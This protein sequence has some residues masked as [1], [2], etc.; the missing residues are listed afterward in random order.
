[1]VLT[2]YDEDADS[3]DEPSQWRV[4]N[5]WGDDHGDKGYALLKKNWFREYVYEVAV[6]KDILSDEHGAALLEEPIQLPPWDPMG[7]LA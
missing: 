1:M 6:H 7:A 5:S 3:P 2:G 4:E